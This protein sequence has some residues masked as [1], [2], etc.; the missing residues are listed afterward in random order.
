MIALYI[1]LALF[2]GLG[3]GYC[4]R[5]IKELSVKVRELENKPE[6]QP[7]VTLGAYRPANESKQSSA[8]INPKTPQQ[9]A[10]IAQEQQRKEAL[11]VGQR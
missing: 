1:C 3:L 2:G 4:W 7:A 10:A 8:V 11:G 9:M 6:K 5:E